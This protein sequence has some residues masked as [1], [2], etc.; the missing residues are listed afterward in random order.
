MDRWHI[1]SKFAL[2]ISGAFRLIFSKDG[3]TERFE[4][5]ASS[6]IY[7]AVSAAEELVAKESFDPREVERILDSISWYKETKHLIYP[8]VLVERIKKVSERSRDM[9]LQV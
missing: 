2:F 3:N 4:L 5:P 8:P 9:R 1:L 6:S 7:A